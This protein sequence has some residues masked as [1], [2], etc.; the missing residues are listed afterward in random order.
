MG[1]PTE[2]GRT[3][4]RRIGAEAP[5]SEH[6]PETEEAVAEAEAEPSVTEGVYFTKASGRDIWHAFNHDDDLIGTIYRATDG[7]WYIKANKVDLPTVHGSAAT[8]RAFMAGYAYASQAQATASR[9]YTENTGRLQ[10]VPGINAPL[11]NEAIERS[12]NATHDADA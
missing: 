11:D 7:K 2:P 8:A 6:T 4:R 10:P 3:G 12:T 1:L 9:P 5:P